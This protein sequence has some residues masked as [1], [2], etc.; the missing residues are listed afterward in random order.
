MSTS[1]A[2]FYNII[3]SVGGALGNANV[4]AASLPLFVVGA[5]AIPGYS[6]GMGIMFFLSLVFVAIF[7]CLVSVMPRTG[8][9]YV[10]T[11]RITNPFLGW[12]EGWGL[13]WTTLGFIGTN[14][15][16]VCWN[17]SGAAEMGVAVMGYSSWTPWVGWWSSLSGVVVVSLIVIAAII[18][19]HVLPARAYFRSFTILVL[20]S[21]ILIMFMIPLFFGATQA[22]FEA[23][24]QH[25][26]G[27]TAAQ[28]ATQAANAGASYIPFSLGALGT[29]TAAGLFMFMG[30]QYSVY[31]AGELKGNVSRNAIISVLSGLIVVA[32][33]NSIYVVILFG[34]MGWGG[35]LTNWGYLFWAGQAPLNGVWPMVP[36]L[37]AM[38]TPNLAIL[39]FVAAIGN[40]AMNILILSAWSAL[41]S[42]LVFAWSMDR[43][44]PSWFA[45]VNTR[46]KSPIRLILLAC[47]AIFALAVLTSLGANPTVTIWFTVIMAILTWFMPGINAIL[48]PFRR[49]DL[50]ELAPSWAKKKIG[51]L[52][53]LPILGVIWVLFML[54]DYGVSFVAPFVS[55]VTSAGL[56]GFAGYAISTGIVAVIIT[57]VAGVIIWFASKWYNKKR[58][59]AFHDIFG[60]LPPE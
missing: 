9:D 40:I 34:L 11:S 25:Y 60:Q 20:V 17:L 7:V 58:G 12:L 42:R 37:G 26:S 48:L 33:V 28:L 51:G 57:N 15:L 2:S 36:L 21:F 29:V 31:F 56:A 49:K 55:A 18:L 8:G 45:A 53:L 14:V 13:V 52:Y 23:A 19:Q 41:I 32:I 16:L 59:I 22:S 54:W 35:V 50:F 24:F 39:G 1:S 43:V 3:S 10:F 44:I 47:V 27:M 30:F 6:V 46:T 38:L 4:I 5:M